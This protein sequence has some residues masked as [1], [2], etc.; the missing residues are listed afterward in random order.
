MRN[1]LILTILLSVIAILTLAFLLANG[2]N[3]SAPVRD[4][5]SSLRSISNSPSYENPSDPNYTVLC[6]NATNPQIRFTK[7][8]PYVECDKGYTTLYVKLDPKLIKKPD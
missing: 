8:G 7:T 6:I 1:R 4:K 3:V 2:N 5:N